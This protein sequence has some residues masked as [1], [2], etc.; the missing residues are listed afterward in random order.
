MS[1]WFRFYDDA[2]DDPKVQRLPPHTFKAWVNLLCL[3]G[4]GGGILPSIADISFHLRMSETDARAVVDELIM[5]GLIDITPEQKLTP[6]NWTGRQY[7][8]DTSKERVRRYRERRKEQGLPKQHCVSGKQKAAIMAKTDGK[9]AYCGTDENMT[10]DHMVPVGRGGTDDFSNLLPACRACNADKRHMTHDEYMS[11]DG[12]KRYSNDDVTLQKRP[13]TTDPEAESNTENKFFPSEQVAAR[14]EGN[15]LGFNFGLKNGRG[16][17]ETVETIAKRAE[18]LGL[19]ATDLLGTTSRAKPKK[20]TAYM[21]ALCVNRLKEQLLGLD[22]QILRDVLWGK[23]EHYATVC[24][25]LLERS[26]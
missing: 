21:T 6:H 3:A 5:C 1:R 26:T 12:R 19:D 16:K 7:V 15:E 10:I 23:P 8:S 20:P 4:K 17:G 22:E 9:C 24:Q 11:W 14:K 13:Q 25:M 2:V 18:G